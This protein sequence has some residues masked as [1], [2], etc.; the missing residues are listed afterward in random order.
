MSDGDALRFPW[1]LVLSVVGPHA[2][3]N[4]NPLMLPLMLERRF[5]CVYVKLLC[6]SVV[7]IMCYDDNPAPIGVWCRGVPGAGVFPV[8][9]PGA[10]PA[11][12]AR[13]LSSPGSACSAPGEPLCGSS[14]S[15]GP[16]QN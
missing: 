8:R 12:A 11:R 5:L 13:G 10:A 4:Q 15:T 16:F 7:S 9:V 3:G 6:F 2:F 14:S 1:S